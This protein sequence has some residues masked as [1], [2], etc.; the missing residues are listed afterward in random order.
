MKEKDVDKDKNRFHRKVANIESF[1]KN[2]NNEEFL[3]T[4][5]RET[6]LQTTEIG[7]SASTSATTTATWFRVLQNKRMVNYRVVQYSW[8]YW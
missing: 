4:Y 2:N 8:Q 5:V 1:A 3:C 6:T 7:T